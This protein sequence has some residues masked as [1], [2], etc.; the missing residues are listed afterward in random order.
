MHTGLE[1]VINLAWKIAA[2]LEG[3]GAPGLLSTY[4][5]ERRPIA[6]RNVNLATRTYNAIAGI[7]GWPGAQDTSAW[8]RTILSIPEHLKLQYCYE[9][10]PI[11]VLDGSAPEPDTP[12]FEPSTRPGARAPHAWLADGRSTID[13]YGDGFVLVRTGADAPDAARLLDAATARR[14]PLTDITIN[15]AAIAALYARKLVLMRPDGHVAWRGD[16]CPVDAGAVIDR[17]RGATIDASR[18]R[19]A[20]SAREEAGLGG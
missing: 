14:V 18:P 16:E 10:S 19:A 12:K 4:E 17:V 13:L 20:A 11:C 15:D 3:W 5:L 6:V 2:V 9:N 7:P 8:S 1:E